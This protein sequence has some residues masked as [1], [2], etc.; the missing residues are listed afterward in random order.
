MSKPDQLLN[1]TN[2]ISEYT[3]VLHTEH[4]VRLNANFT[5]KKYVNL[6]AI[7]NALEPSKVA[8]SDGITKDDIT[9]SIRNISIK[10]GK[11]SESI[12]C[13]QGNAWLL[14]TDLQKTRLQDSP[15]CSKLC[16]NDSL[17][18]DILKLLPNA[19][20]KNTDKDI[21][22]F[23][24]TKLP[25]YKTGTIIYLPN[26]RIVMQWDTQKGVAQIEDYSVGISQ[27]S[28][29]SS[30]L[31]IMDFESTTGKQF[32]HRS[33]IGVGAGGFFY[34]HV[35]AI[36]KTHKEAVSVLGPILIDETPPY[37]KEKPAVTISGDKILVGW[38]DD[39]IYDIE[40]KEKINQVFI[41]IG[42][43]KYHFIE[44]EIL[45]VLSSFH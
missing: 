2:T 12:V 26:D 14:T 29:N 35:K 7:N 20:P 1:D 9:P 45:N 43:S 21:S 27:T 11:W 38:K 30:S 44:L 31:D 5:G 34:M 39:T 36:S 24:C 22:D 15:E 13:L 40:Q 37:F 17:G 18:S 19:R 3:T 33:H 6:I 25:T 28:G 41:Q 8:C 16:V 23:L 4:S 42:N 32:F 10:H